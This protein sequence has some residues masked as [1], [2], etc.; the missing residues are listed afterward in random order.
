MTSESKDAG[1]PVPAAQ[2]AS[3]RLA[4]HPLSARQIALRMALM[5]GIA[6]AWLLAI[7][8]MATALPAS[9]GSVGIPHS[10]DDLKELAVILE[11]YS[12]SHPMH[13]FSL[14]SAVYM[15]KQSFFIPGSVLLNVLGGAL[16][17]YA[18]IPLISLLAAVGSTLGYLMSLHIFGQVIFGSLISRS[19]VLSWRLAIDDCRDNMLAYLISLR[20]VPII[21][22][23]FINIASPFV[24]VPI[25]PFFLSTA[26]GLTP[27]HFI[28]VQA[29]RTLSKL[30]T[31]SDIINFWTLLQLAAVSAVIVLPVLLKKRIEGLLRSSAG[32]QRRYDRVPASDG[33][34]PA[35]RHPEVL[36]AQDR[37]FVFLTIRLVDA[38]DVKIDKAAQRLSFEATADSTHYAFSLDLFAA[39]KEDTWHETITNRTVTLVVE[40]VNTRERFWPRLQ[41]AAGKLPWLKTDFSKFV[42]DNFDDPEPE[43]ME[44][45]MGFNMNDQ[46]MNMLG[47][48][49]QGFEDSDDEAGE[50]D[51]EDAAGIEA[52]ASTIKAAV[53][54]SM[55]ESET[56]SA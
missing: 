5:A 49:A 17:G 6:F 9:F 44:N 33:L 3:S 50:Q 41:Q 2:G 25:W 34:E 54:S 30:N 13:I 15:F 28:C 16:Y 36:W 4:L 37:R 14:F 11:A 47:N 40:K 26:I 31:M 21:P 20:S 8:M 52:T 45:G 24:G 7:Y 23:W 10:L 27:F 53:D 35:S 42:D 56:A 46:M 29:A 38:K 48:Q 19:R 51:E 1:L 55:A 22:G 18:A 32:A 39:V 12:S 43:D